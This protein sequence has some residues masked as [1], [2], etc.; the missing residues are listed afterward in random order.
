MQPIVDFILEIDRL[1]GVTRR[2]RPLG[3]DRYETLDRLEQQAARRDQ[4]VLV[5]TPGTKT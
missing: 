2:N 5:V 4:L 1:K 3:L